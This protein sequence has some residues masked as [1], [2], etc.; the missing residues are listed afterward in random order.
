M[1]TARTPEE[2]ESMLEDAFV[3]H[4]RETLADLFDPGAVLHPAGWRGPAHGRDEISRLVAELWNHQHGYVADPL[5]VLQARDTALVLS[6]P[7]V[8]VA[9]RTP[10]G[11]WRYAIVH[12]RRDAG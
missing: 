7:A 8:N 6:R 2:L 10:D 9:R 12:L 5:T 1:G 11:Y 4:D 3:L